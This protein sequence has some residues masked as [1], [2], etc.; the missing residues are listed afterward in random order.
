MLNIAGGEG[1]IGADSTARARK[2]RFR[3]R[4]G[5]IAWENE[6]IETTV[7]K[8]AAERAKRG[9]DPEDRVTIRLSLT[10]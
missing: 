10:S 5:R 7:G 2:P 6:V 9:L 8:V 1:Q 4:S 3:E